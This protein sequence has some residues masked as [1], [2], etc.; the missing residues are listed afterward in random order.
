VF[1][2]D[3]ISYQH[4]YNEI[5]NLNYHGLPTQITPPIFQV[6]SIYSNGYGYLNYGATSDYNTAYIANDGRIVKQY[7]VNE[8]HNEPNT[9]NY[10]YRPNVQMKSVPSYVLR[11]DINVIQPRV[12]DD[13]FSVANS[14][15]GVPTFLNKN[16]GNVALGS[17]SLGVIRSNNG[18]VYLGSGSLG[19]ISHRDHYHSVTDIF[20]RRQKPSSSSPTNF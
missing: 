11:K 4:I 18:D 19:Y 5:N 8:H 14:Q 16:H 10:R 17:G 15:T 3:D 12:F 6:P 1:G 9:F 20:N 2:F 13:D 7:A